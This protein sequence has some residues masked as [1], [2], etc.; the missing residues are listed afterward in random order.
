MKNIASLFAVLLLIMLGIVNPASAQTPASMADYWA[1]NAE[2]K[3]VR[4]MDPIVGGVSDNGGAKTVRVSVD[5]WYLFSPYA[6]QSACTRENILKLG[7]RVFKS[8]DQGA[9]WSA[10]AD[11][12]SLGAQAASD[13]EATDGDA[14]YDASANKWRMI[15][16]CLSEN[17]TEGWQVCYAERL[18][19]D[20]MGTFTPVAAN[21]VVRSG[22]LWQQICASP[23][24]RCRVLSDNRPVLDEG[25][26]KIS[27]FDG[28]YFWVTFHGFVP[29]TASLPSRGFRGVAKTADFVTWIAGN[30]SQGTPDDAMLSLEDA[31]QWRENWNTGGPIGPGDGSI[32]QDGGYFYQTVEVPDLNLGCRDGQNWNVGIYRADSLAKKTGQWEG[33]PAG[34]PIFY[35]GK[36]VNGGT[37]IGCAIQYAQIFKDTTVSPN[38]I[39]LKLNRQS[40]EIGNM[41]TDLYR[42]T[43]TRNILKNGDLWK[44]NAEHW[45]RTFQG[46]TNLAVFRW[47]QTAPDRNQFM[48][49]NCGKPACDPGQSVYQ[50][51]DATPYAGQIVD[52]GGKFSTGG[53]TGKMFLRLHQLDVNNALVDEK[54]IE[55]YP[56]DTGFIT[57]LSAPVQVNPA[58][59]LLRYQVYLETGTVTYFADEMHVTLH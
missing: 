14:I 50:D 36:P 31:N 1:G 7:I 25:T 45:N 57:L 51:V 48:A 56:N 10:P 33:L 42:L 49:T 24:S 26:L 8:T 43:L 29:D 18:G 6:N 21:P 55:A 13:C 40:K 3:L 37:N 54:V 59:K 28:T 20:P 35:S 47:P 53:G 15:Y 38:V 12:I 46:Q 34:N 44:A 41:G 27:H 58:T 52:F 19:A 32:I 11:A 5:A 39:Y 17:P 4:Q 23:T 16:Q 9:T 22:T 2:W 30:V